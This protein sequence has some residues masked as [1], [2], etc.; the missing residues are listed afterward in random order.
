METNTNGQEFAFYNGFSTG[1]WYYVV[2]TRTDNTVK[3]YLNGSYAGSMTIS[4]SDYL[5]LSQI[6]FK[7]RSFR[8]TIDELGI[9]NRALTGADVTSLYNNGKGLSYPFSALGNTATTQSL[10]GDDV[11]ALAELAN[12]DKSLTKSTDP[13]PDDF[14]YPNPA[15]DNLFF[16]DIRDTRARVSIYDM[17]GRLVFT[18]QITEHSVDI[19]SL[20]KGIYLVKLEDNGR[21]LMR[22]LMKE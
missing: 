10:A 15:R 4:G 19:S 6:G 14:F 20:A 2:L 16:N 11:N 21:T 12:P 18:Q 8:G 22:K 9:W 17:H 1:T 13:V 3:L 5:S 7:G